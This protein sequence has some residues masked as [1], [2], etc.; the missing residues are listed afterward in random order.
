MFATHA[1]FVAL[2]DGLPAISGSEELEDLLKKEME[3]ASSEAPRR[4]MD[5]SLSRLF[6][7]VIGHRSVRDQGNCGG[8]HRLACGR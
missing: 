7:I 1:D 3:K 8:L 5:P 4:G 2:L 6:P